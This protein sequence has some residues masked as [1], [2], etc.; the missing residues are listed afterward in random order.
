ME[1]CISTIIILLVYKWLSN[2]SRNSPAARRSPYY[3]SI[4][5][6]VA[7][8]SSAIER[9]QSLL[10]LVGADSSIQNTPEWQKQIKTQG[11]EIA[12][13]PQRVALMQP[14][15]DCMTVHSHLSGMAMHY[16]RWAGMFLEA[17]DKEDQTLADTAEDE[18]V[19]GDAASERAT[20]ELQRLN[21]SD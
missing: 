9:F 1:A 13:M 7:D 15:P 18:K 3:A 5:S 4:T 21:A 11:A 2:R 10:N 17:F 14:P 12:R 6:M 20:A 8:C 19:R 16:A